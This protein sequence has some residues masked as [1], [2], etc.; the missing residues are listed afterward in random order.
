MKKGCKNSKEREEYN[1]SRRDYN[2][3]YMKDLRENNRE[4]YNDYYKD[5]MRKLRDEKYKKE[6]SNYFPKKELS[7]KLNEN[8]IYEGKLKEEIFSILGDKNELS[9]LKRRKVFYFPPWINAIEEFMKERE[10]IK[11]GERYFKIQK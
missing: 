2:L 10:Y 11:D 8:E 7:N 4:Y 1:K 6:I 5:S 9:I 3:N